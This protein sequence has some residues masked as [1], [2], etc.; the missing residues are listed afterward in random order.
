MGCV[1]QNLYYFCLSITLIKEATEPQPGLKDESRTKQHSS[2]SSQSTERISEPMM[3]DAVWFD[4]PKYDAERDN[5]ELKK[6]GTVKKERAHSNGEVCCI[7]LL[8]ILG[9]L[10]SVG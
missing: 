4:K 7:I 9:L 3:F 8:L 6:A 5:V 2:K 1:T 10:L